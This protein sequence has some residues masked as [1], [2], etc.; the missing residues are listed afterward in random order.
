[1]LEALSLKRAIRARCE[2]AQRNRLESWRAGRRAGRIAK[3]RMTTPKGLAGAFAGGLAVGL[4]TRSEQRVAQARRFG[5]LMKDYLPV[6]TQLMFQAGVDTAQT[7]T[8]R[9]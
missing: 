6:A 3:T 2:E 1:M 7:P 4:I 5:Q 9:G 8:K